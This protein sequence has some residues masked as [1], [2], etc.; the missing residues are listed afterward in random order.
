EETAGN[1]AAAARHYIEA[2]RLFA[3]GSS[4]HLR[5]DTRAMAALVKAR[6]AY[7]AAQRHVP[8]QFRIVKIPFDGKSFEA[9]LHLPPGK[10]PFPVVVYSNGS[11]V[12]KEQVG[13]ALRG[14]LAMRNIALL[15]IDMPGIGSGGA[16]DL[17]PA[18]DVLHVAAIEH[19]RRDPAI[20]PT[21]VAAMGVSFGG[22]AAARLFLRPGLGLRGVV[23]AC[24]PLRSV[25]MLPPAAYERLPALTLDGVRDRVGLPVGVSTTDRAATM[26]P[27]ALDA[28]D[29]ASTVKIDTP[30]LILGTEADPVAP[31]KDVGLLVARASKVSTIVS[32]ELGHCPGELLTA[33]TAAAWLA[34]RLRE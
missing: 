20:D 24:G 26:R 2:A 11:D 34:L 1:G 13:D 14:E 15:S 6:A 17:T 21:R 3:I 28:P 25:F 33:S 27:F 29:P 16:Y 18:S 31:L 8:G 5:T 30:L 32:R 4:P 9:Y 23:E 22:H 19:M 7:Q 10:G 12:V